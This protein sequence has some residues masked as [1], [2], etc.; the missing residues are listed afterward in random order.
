M[1]KVSKNE[2]RYI[3]S[4][5]CKVFLAFILITGLGILNGRADDS[6]AQETRL[7]F[8]VKNS[9]VK[10]V[11]NRIEKSTGF[12]FMYENNVIDVNSKVDFEAKNESIESILERLFGGRVGYRIV[13]KHILLF[14]N[15]KQTDQTVLPDVASVQQQQRTVTGK[16]TDP[17]GQ[18]LPGATVMIK[19]TSIGTITDADGNY[20]LRN[21]PDDATLVFS[22]VGMQTQEINVGNRTRIDVTMQEEAVALQEVVAIGYGTRTRKD[23]TSAVSNISSETI[24]K[25]IAM[26]PENAMQG[27]MSGVYV[28]G[29]SGD[30]MNRPTIRIRGVNTWG[31]SNPLY[32]IDGIPITEMGAGIE[33]TNARIADVRGPLNIMSLI[34]PNDIESI[35]VLKDASAA[36]VYG[37]R[38]ANGV[39]LITTKSGRKGKPT[40]DFSTRY[41]VQNLTQEL[42]WLTTPQYTKFV[43]DV[44]A[45]NPD[46][47]P[48]EDNTGRFDPNDPRYLGNSPTY[49]WQDAVRNENA[50]TQDYSVTVSGGT[51]NTDY[52]I[53]LGYSSMKGTLLVND[54]S[55]YSGTVKVDTKINSWVK[56]GL[57]Y[58]LVNGIGRNV[59]GPYQYF[60]IIRSAPWQ[61]IYATGDIPGYKGYAY[62]VGGIQPDGTYSTQKL[63]GQG[64][65]INEVG[66]THTNDQKYDSWR[67]IG[68]I[69]VELTPIQGL[70]IK[71]TVS[72]DRYTTTRY[73]FQDY[74]GKPFDYTSGDPRQIAGEKS[75]GSYGERQ[76][77]NNNL[78]Q[79]LMVEYKNSFGENN[80]DFLFNFS[81]QKYDAKYVGSSTDYLTTKKDYLRNL[82][83]ERK[84]TS[85]GG[86][87]MRW[88]LQGYLWR[89]SY[90]FGGKY[91][92]DA[93]VR[94]DGSARFA[95]EK[96]WGTF[97]SLSGAWRM[98]SESFM[99]DITWID[100]LKLRAGWGQLG[101]QEVRDMAYLSTIAGGPHYA[102]G[103]A[104]E[105]DRPASGT[106]HDGATIFGIPNRDLTWEKTET[107][108]IGFDSQL[109][110]SIS[111]S[112]EYYHKITHGIL[113]EIDIPV[114][115]GVV[116][117]P[118]ANVAEVRNQ[119]FEFNANW[120]K[121]IGKVLLSI[122]GNFT[123]NDNKVLTTYKHIPTG[124]G[125]IEEGYPIFYHKAYKVGGIFQTDQEA[126]EW[127]ATHD[128]ANYQKSKVGAGDFY[129]QDLRGAPKEEGTFYSEGPDGKIDSYDMV[130]VG[131][132]IPGFFY[133]VNLNAAYRDFDI[134][135]NFSGVGD[136]MKYNAIKA[137]TFMPTE[138]DNVTDI[139]YK[140]WT[141]N[142]KQNKYPRLVFGDPAQNLRYSDFFFES[143]AYFRFQNLQIGY[144][145]P[146]SFYNSLKN[147]IRN[148]RI[149]AGATNIFTITKYTG[150]DPDNDAYPTPKT[151]YVGFTM[152]F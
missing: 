142:N 134:S 54:L 111:F 8:S 44:F 143:G 5:L 99:K 58:R 141:E 120:Q 127:M 3:F 96:R 147:Q 91:Y 75:V 140:A 122:G 84:Y 2:E 72:M 7:T 133:G 46:K 119:G 79:E 36:A 45:S 74:D 64:T 150:L 38:A 128:D 49:S 113:Q 115:V 105:N 24:S 98:S 107:F 82:G 116:E 149:Y 41:G 29:I 95:P 80:I 47:T 104:S 138:G 65:R 42:N 43:Q 57:N 59:W 35:S 4:H 78:M 40:I 55:R 146:I 25:T 92:L 9:T 15:E 97:P 118:V 16:V 19:G 22:F 106:Y 83:G 39:V 10:S 14:R 121:E 88:A 6:H 144:T 23:I 151:F 60:D 112:A 130:Y 109:F 93:T 100:D 52:Y 61:P 11:L 13:G 34:D 26:S 69:Y 18:P 66:R 103:N 17:N 86:E 132:S 50:P 37:M 27:T 114:S 51:D 33:G 48:S 123:T 1:E 137:G 126:Q 117:T 68:N 87:Q 20:S 28:A 81:N 102:M 110:R 77:F 56:T 152:K 70:S 67:N 62:V 136:V 63:Y 124:G 21:V 32:V 90:N 129:F 145:L 89:L 73:E 30:P 139:V 125:T 94:R 53:S 131:K 71:G 12:S 108:D 76:T 101:N 85:V 31:I 135:A 148:V